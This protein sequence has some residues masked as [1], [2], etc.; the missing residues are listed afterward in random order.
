MNTNIEMTAQN[1]TIHN[2]SNINAIGK[3]NSAHCKPIVC[4]ETGDTYSSIK[5]AATKVGVHYV[6]MC[7]HMRRKLKS[8]KG[9][10]YSYLS[11]VL[12]NPD[13]IL[14][15]LRKANAENE[16]LKQ[17]ADDARKWRE[18]QARL[19]A[20]AKAEAERKRKHE[21]AVAKARAKVDR[22]RTVHERN[23]AMTERSSARLSEAEAELVALLSE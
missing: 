13:D 17:D 2:A 10:H 7:Q 16:A 6:T 21:K 19:E 8:V 1:I 15:Q 4:V 23:V 18:Y 22:R 3:H 9:L 11:D 20:E 12:D 5:D 14:A